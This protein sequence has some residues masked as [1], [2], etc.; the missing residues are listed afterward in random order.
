V[1][2]KTALIPDF[3]NLDYALSIFILPL[4]VFWWSMWYGGAEPGGGAYVVQRI[5]S[6]KNERHAIGASLFFQ[7]CHYALRP[8]PW[9]IVAL[10]S[11]IVF[12]D[13][14]SLRRA[15]PA[16]PL[17]DDL[18]Y[19]AMLTF[20]P[21]GLLGLVVASLAAAYMSTISTQLNLMS[22]YVVNDLYGRFYRPAAPEK[23][24]VLVGRVVTLLILCLSGTVALQLESALQVF[25]VLLQI[26]AGTGLVFL[27]RWFW[28]RVNAF[29]EIAAMATALIAAIYFNFIHARVGLAPLQNWQVLIITITLTTC[30]WIIV[31]FLT[32]PTED[33]VLRRFYLSVNPGG[34]GWRAVRRR[35]EAEGIP[36]PKSAAQWDVPTALVCAAAGCVM[37]YA[38][39]FATGNWIY[40]R[41]GAAVLLTVVAA[42]AG[43]VPLVL[44]RRLNI[45]SGL[46]QLKPDPP[47]TQSRSRES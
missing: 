3:S 32:R 26:G 45:E 17:G 15:F 37:V 13:L 20:L 12:P 5:L 33:G 14:D 28:W 44:W 40:G 31:T 38:A 11:I 29:S 42:V 34:P 30:T 23:E 7:V 8:W 41:T 9:I 24:R 25:R 27:L 2:A 1:V 21:S 6:A 35:A 10:A 19:P 39:L 47:A 43:A 46:E 16:V 36:L 4:T 18:G 22:S